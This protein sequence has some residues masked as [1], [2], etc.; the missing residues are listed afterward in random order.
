MS[1]SPKETAEASGFAIEDVA[2][3]NNCQDV[4]DSIPKLMRDEKNIEG[5]RRKIMH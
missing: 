4:I 1:T 3:L 5:E 2:E